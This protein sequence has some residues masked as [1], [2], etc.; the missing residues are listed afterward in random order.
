MDQYF[1]DTYYD[2]SN[3]ASFS[4]VAKLRKSALEAG[5][6]DA[7]WGK[8]RKWL[9]KQEAY[10][11]FKKSRRKFKRNFIPLVRI[12]FQWEVDL[13]DFKDLSDQNDGYKYILC[14]IDNFSKFAWTVPL[15]SK[16]GK[17]TA[18]A[19]NSIFDKGRKPSNV[20]RSDLGGEFKSKYVTSLLKE[21]NIKPMYALNEKKAAIVERFIKTIK[22]KL[23]KDMYHRQSKRWIDNLQKFT[24][25]YNESV[26]ST[27]GFAPKDV[28][29]ENEPQVLVNH[30]FKKRTVKKSSGLKKRY[31]FKVG[32]IIR[33]STLLDKFSREYDTTY[34]Q[35]LFKIHR[36]YRREGLPMYKIKEWDGD[37]I[38]GTF[39]E[40]ELTRAYEP[41]SYKIDKVI[42]KRK[43]RGKTEYLVQW[44]GWPSKYNT[45]V[46]VSDMKDL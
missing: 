39:Y 18:A 5:F 37:V 46:K 27:I 6:A 44:R 2:P 17:E 29:K 13:L 34:S 15:K 24:S 28:S 20:L 9:V 40:Q 35:E 25:A 7:S 19:L 45:W 30:Y 12:D 3:P 21:N 33:V 11:L 36:R 26:H 41:D 38:T 10:T 1:E 43:V 23:T 4:S 14:A 16:T 22:L 31:K 42:R 32:D 8:T